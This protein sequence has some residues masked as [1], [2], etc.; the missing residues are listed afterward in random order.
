MSR[1]AYTV[2]AETDSEGSIRAYVDWLARGH[3]AEVVEAGALSGQAIRLETQPGQSYR[4]EARYVFGSMEAFRAYEAGPA[5]RLRAEGI[6]LFGPESPNP[7]RFI[8][9]L[10]LIA[11][12]LP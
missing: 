9:T 5:V 4:A 1:V 3:I 7:M 11:A 12:N 10:G 6:G 8:R 2:I